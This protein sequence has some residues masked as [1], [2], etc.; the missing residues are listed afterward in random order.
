M[1]T[2]TFSTSNPPLKLSR[3][4]RRLRSTAVVFALTSPETGVKV[5]DLVGLVTSAVVTV[6]VGTAE[7]EEDTRIATVTVEDMVIAVVGLVPAI[8]A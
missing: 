1:H 2:L 4:S 5:A 8:A 7:E 6:I 3:S